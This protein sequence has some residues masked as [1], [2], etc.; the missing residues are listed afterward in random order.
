MKKLIILFIALLTTFC[1]FGCDG[2]DKPSGN[3]LDEETLLKALEDNSWFYCPEQQLYARFN[4]DER[5][6]QEMIKNSGYFMGMEISKVEKVEDNKYQLTMHVPAFA[7]NEMTDPYD[8][9][10]LLFTLYYD[11]NKPTEFDCVVEQPDHSSAYSSH[12]VSDKGLSA[13]QLL[14]LLEENSW[15]REDYQ[16]YLCRFNAASRTYQETLPN[17]SYFMQADIKDIKYL[18]QKIYELTMH[19]PGF[20]GNDETE[21]Y[22][23]YDIIYKID[24]DENNPTQFECYVGDEGIFH[25]FV[26][27]K[28]LSLEELLKLL[29]ANSNF[30]NSEHGTIAWFNANEKTYEETMD[31]TSYYLGAAITDFKYLQANEYELTLHVDGFAGNEMTDPYDPY[32]IRMVITY[33]T[34]NPKEYDVAM[35]YLDSGY[36]VYGHFVSQN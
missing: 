4:K 36:T 25:F 13:N 20:A 1:L 29:E 21:P 28:G 30:F 22:E 35:T 27:D 33:D 18:G 26:S 16:G 34:S 12:F 9:Y 10:D 2:G 17:S 11:L 8:A 5:S 14:D 6:Y 7:G 3:T 31:A 32:D 19:V 24:F 23:A 15:Y